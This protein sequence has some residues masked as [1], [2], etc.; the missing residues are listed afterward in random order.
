MALATVGGVTMRLG[1][2]HCPGDALLVGWIGMVAFAIYGIALTIAA[3][4][5]WLR[6]RP[7]AR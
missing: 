2:F 7:S 4:S 6:T 1:D 3:R 5:Y